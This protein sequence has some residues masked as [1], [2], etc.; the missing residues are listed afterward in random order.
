MSIKQKNRV[1][2]EKI[3]KG[4]RNTGIIIVCVG[5]FFGASYVVWNKAINDHTPLE[6]T[7]VYTIHNRDLFTYLSCEGEVQ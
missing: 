2:R 6:Y 5:V 3:M 1:R 7:D 4:L